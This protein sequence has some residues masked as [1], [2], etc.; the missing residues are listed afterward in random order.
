M[1]TFTTHRNLR[2]N[3]ALVKKLVSQKMKLK[4]YPLN[5]RRL[6]SSH[7]L[8]LKKFLVIARL[9]SRRK[10][11]LVKRKRN[12]RSSVEKDVNKRESAKKPNK[13]KRAS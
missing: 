3:N 10:L 5:V 6:L 13:P 8:T 11:L 4:A 12:K 2:V 9:T 7:L 1:P